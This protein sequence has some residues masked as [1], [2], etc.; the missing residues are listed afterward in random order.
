MGDLRTLRT[1][2]LLKKALLELLSKQSFD[3]IK[4]NDIC[5]AAMI[6]RTTFYSHFS[7]KY[8]LLDYVVKNLEEEL[9]E[10]F[11]VK[12]YSSS[13]DF[14]MG[15]INHLLEF[16]GSNKM[17][18]RNILNNNYGSGIIT[19]FHNSAIKHISE[20]IEKETRTGKNFTVPTVVMAE[21]YSGAVTSTI[22]WWLKTNSNIS[23]K[24]LCNHIVSLIFDNKN[25]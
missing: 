14:Y 16:L 21:F 6:H 13:R 5:E 25:N 22:L 12:S 11:D 24:D 19:V 8:E 4:V 9:L 23:E 1:Y 15:L 17:F 3:S 20:L 10:G 2:T 7:D 18:F